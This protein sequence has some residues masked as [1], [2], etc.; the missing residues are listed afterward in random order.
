MPTRYKE[1]S[2]SIVLVRIDGTYVY[3]HALED[4]HVDYFSRDHYCSILL[5]GVVSPDLTFLNV[6]AGIPGSVHDG[7]VCCV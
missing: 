1:T 5:Q 2:I 7:S 4:N 6:F 3:L